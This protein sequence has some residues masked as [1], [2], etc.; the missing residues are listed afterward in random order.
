MPT[1][2]RAFGAKL[3]RH[4]WTAE[5]S[6]ADHRS[7]PNEDYTVGDGLAVVPCREHLLQRLFE[8]LERYPDVA[9]RQLERVARR[10]E[11]FVVDLA[12]E[13][14]PVPGQTARMIDA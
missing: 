2:A 8:R 10:L 12:V 3:A 9:E 1:R 4:M 7:Q 5:E 14:Q 6:G 11:E 13:H